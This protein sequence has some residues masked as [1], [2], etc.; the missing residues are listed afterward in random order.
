MLFKAIWKMENKNDVYP[1]AATEISGTFERKICANDR[2][3]FH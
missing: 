2:V 1:A 3:F